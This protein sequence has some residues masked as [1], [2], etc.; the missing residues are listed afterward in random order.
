MAQ[1]FTPYS[2]I[3]PFFGSAKPAWVPPLEQERI[4]SYQMYEEIYWN[5]PET[6]S[7]VARG[8]ENQSIYVPSARTI[9]DATDRYTGNG[10]NFQV[11]PG[12]G[13][14]ADVLEAQL[15]FSTLFKRERFF[16]IFQAQKLYGIIRGD[17]IWHITADENKLP[18][19]RI[20]LR[21]VDPASYFPVYDDDNLDRIIKIHLA[22]QFVDPEGN[23]VF[24]RRQTYERDDAGNIV[25]TL[26]VF[27]LKDWE[28]DTTRPVRVIAGPTTLPP[29]ITAFPVYHIKNFEEPG[30]PFGSSE[31]RGFERIMAAVNQSVSDEDIALALEGL[32][33][34]TTDMGRPVDDEGNPVSWIL[35]PGRVLE[36][37]GDFKRVNGIGS[38]APYGDHIERLIR[39]LR[40]A[41]S[42]SDSTIGRVNVQVAESGI[43]LALEMSPMLAKA[44]KKDVSILD[45]LA[46]MFYG[47]QRWMKV[48]DSVDVTACEIL[49]TL[50]EKLPVNRTALIKDLAALVSTEP[51]IMSTQTAR[52]ILAK[53]G[54]EFA[55]DEA[56]RIAAQMDAASSRALTE[57]AGAGLGSNNGDR[58]NA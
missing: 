18:G 24:V 5:H 23:K 46:Q 11:S 7:L 51:P 42:T 19:E 9:V 3:A 27:E 22:E 55:P 33:I 34:Y 15:A 20:S 50:G 10:L 32:G 54:V 6:F 4:A 29:D 30:N 37:A 56:D 58:A 41:S 16:S 36:N 39:F 17:S 48:F 35:G 12:V 1:V 45:T 31:I 57:L 44:G 13:T 43:A 49:P 47:L 38:V 52:E 53:N 28:L 8:A 21:T 2:T 25:S 26:A 40:E 14:P